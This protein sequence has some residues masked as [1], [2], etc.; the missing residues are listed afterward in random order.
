MVTELH[1]PLAVD[2]VIDVEPFPPRVHDPLGFERLEVLRHRRL[3][4][5]EPGGELADPERPARIGREEVDDPE[6]GEVAE[7]FERPGHLGDDLGEVGARVRGFV[8]VHEILNKRVLIHLYIFR[9]DRPRIRTRTHASS[10][11][12]E[13]EFRRCGRR[14]HRVLCT[15]SLRAAIGADQKSIVFLKT[16]MFL[17]ASIP[18]HRRSEGMRTDSIP[19][20]TW[21]I[22]V[23]ARCPT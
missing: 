18:G 14:D 4:D 16:R 6:A 10:L 9:F 5:V 12:A 3:R 8:G 13:E 7:R 21:R 1:H 2:R 19:S 11:P 22:L 23:R 17:K 20:E 15:G